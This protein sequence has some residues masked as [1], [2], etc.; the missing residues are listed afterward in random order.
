M[1]SNTRH[2]SK[3]AVLLIR[4]KKD[5]TIRQNHIKTFFLVISALL[6]F[7]ITLTMVTLFTLNN[8]G[9]HR[10]QLSEYE[11]MV[12]ELNNELNGL[13]RENTDLSNKLSVLTETVATQVAL[14]EVREDELTDISLPKGFPLGGTGS[15]TIGEDEEDEL[16]LVFHATEGNTIITV[17]AGVVE[18]IEPDEKYGTRLTINHLNGYKSVYLNK[19]QPLV[20]TGEE[21]GKRYI[22]FL[23]GSD[24]KDLGFQIIEN[25]RQVDPMEIMEISG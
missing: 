24:N 19:G 12:S 25:E 18:A 21:L 22:L 20:K 4:K 8:T 14:A 5:G 7:G 6:I 1:D 16:T 23:I 11:T 13:Q 10:T 9:S 17:G 15:A 2:K 3:I